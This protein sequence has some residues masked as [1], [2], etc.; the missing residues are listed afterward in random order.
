MFNAAFVT[1]WIVF[2][3]FVITKGGQWARQQALADRVAR[4]PGAVMV[5]IGIAWWLLLSPSGFGAAL[6]LAALVWEASSLIR[7][8]RAGMASQSRGSTS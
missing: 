6:A 5:A 7:Q 1:A 4:R 3:A 2:W 8:Q